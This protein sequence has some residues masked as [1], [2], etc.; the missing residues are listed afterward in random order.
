MLSM[1][2]RGKQGSSIPQVI[3]PGK[4]AKPGLVHET[5]FKPLTGGGRPP[6]DPDSALQSLMSRHGKGGKDNNCKWQSKG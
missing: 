6:Q 4:P 5:R 1:I 3:I 2:H